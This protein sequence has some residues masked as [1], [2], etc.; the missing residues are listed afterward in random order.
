MH[1]D[2]YMHVSHTVCGPWARV[3]AQSVYINNVFD[4][5]WKTSGN[6]KGL[7]MPNHARTLLFPDG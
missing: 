1:T 2:M 6:P 3:W 7:S 4:V 5:V